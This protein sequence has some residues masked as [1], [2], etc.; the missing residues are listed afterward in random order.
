MPVSNI[1]IIIHSSE[2][3]RESETIKIEEHD[4]NI[5]FDSV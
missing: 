3:P 1:P 4:D 2:R 5:D